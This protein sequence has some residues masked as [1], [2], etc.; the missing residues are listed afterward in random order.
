MPKYRTKI[1]GFT[2]LLLIYWSS[3]LAQFKVLDSGTEKDLYTMFFVNESTGF[4]GGDHGV[5]VKTENYGKTWN[6]LQLD[7]PYR[8]NGIYFINPDTGYVVGENS[9]FYKTLNGGGTWNLINLPVIADFTAI[10]FVNKKTGYVIGH[11]LDGGVFIKT[12]DGGE[13][14]ISKVINEN[15]AKKNQDKGVVCDELYLLNL[16]FLNEEAGLI[17][18]YAFNYIDGKK[19][20]ICKTDDGGKSFID[21][22]PQPETEHWNY[23][24]EIVSLNY[25]TPHDA[26]AIFNTGRGNSFLYMSDYKIRNFRQYNNELFHDYHELYFSSWFLDRYVG[27]FTSLVN[28]KPQVLKTFD[29]GDS[30]MFLNPP[31]DNTLYCTFF[32]DTENGYFAGQN[33]TILHYTDNNNILRKDASIVDGQY[34]E[35]PFTIAIPND[36]STKTQIFIYNLDIS[37]L[38]DINLSLFDRYGEAVE[39]KRKRVRIY[40]NEIRIRIKTIELSSGLYFYTLKDQEQA[41]INGK[42]NVGSFAQM[43]Y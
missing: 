29:L 8:I 11:G 39:I 37:N 24:Y 27:Y 16:S 36:R 35:P 43:V 17:G 22:S 18:G 7:T 40:E 34:A 14:W 26:C 1:L 10:E 28:G 38:N 21:V 30:F 31:T 20:F 32:T 2:C 9:S 19:P 42:I 23:G 33:G 15:C 25:M 41:L 5:V 13:T 6:L 12:E 4:A 3:G